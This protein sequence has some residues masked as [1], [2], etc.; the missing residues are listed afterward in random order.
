M[1]RYFGGQAVPRGLYLNQHNL[2][3]SQINAGNPR[4]PG[5]GEDKFLRIPVAAALVIGPLFGLVFIMALPLIGIAGLLFLVAY[6]AGL[7]QNNAARKLFQ[8]FMA[9]H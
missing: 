7:T 2:E 3:F 9:S 4:L 8:V 6:K 1:K 5:A